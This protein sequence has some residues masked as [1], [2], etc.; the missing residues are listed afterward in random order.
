MIPLHMGALHPVE[1]ALTLLLAFGPFV[2]LGALVWWRRREE[3]DEQR[4]EHHDEHH[5]EP[6]I[7][8]DASAERG[9]DRGRLS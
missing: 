7:V 8:Q 6:R 3:H 1:Q 2:L 9:G 4:D 5:D